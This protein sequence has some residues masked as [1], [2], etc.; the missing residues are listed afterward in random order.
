MI[1]VI[2]T[3]EDAI[4]SVKKLVELTVG[5]D[6]HYVA[7]TSGFFMLTCPI[8]VAGQRLNPDKR[9]ETGSSYIEIDNRTYELDSFG[10]EFIS[11]FDEFF[12][13][14]K[15]AGMDLELIL[16]EMKKLFTFPLEV[17]AF[18]GSD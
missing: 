15:T 11:M 2:V 16:K 7:N 3:E 4:A 8:S 9:V 17:L 18:E 1:K 13:S 14:C 5:L 12:L 10:E 6:A